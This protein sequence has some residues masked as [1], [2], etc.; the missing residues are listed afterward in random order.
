MNMTIADTYEIAMGRWS[1]RL[2]R[3]FLDFVAAPSCGALVDVGCGTGSLTLAAATRYPN[4]DIV[5]IDL[6]PD[7]LTDALRSSA[8]NVRFETGDASAL[9]FADDSFDTSFSQLLLN[10]LD[11]PAGAVGEMV[12]VTRSNGRIAATVWDRVGGLTFIRLFLDVAALVAGT[13]GE[14]LRA[15]VFDVPYQNED[16]LF[17]LWSDAGLE[18]VATTTLAVRMDFIDFDDYWQSL[19]GAHSLIRNFFANQPAEIAHEIQQATM[20]AYLGGKPD[21]RRSLVASALAVRGI[22]AA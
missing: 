9:P 1:R 12:R 5:G 13:E 7:Y 19:M 16:D 14:E 11:G 10:D 8:P 18:D 6:M 2:S 4:A 3:S 15:R 22:V 17:D 21:G 20:R